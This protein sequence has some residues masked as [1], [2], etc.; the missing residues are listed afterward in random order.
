MGSRPSKV[1]PSMLGIRGQAFRE[2][3][4]VISSGPFLSKSP[5]MP[6][7]QRSSGHAGYL[8]NGFMTPRSRGKSAIYSMARTPYSRVNL[9]T[10]L[11][12]HLLARITSV[13]ISTFF[14]SQVLI[15]I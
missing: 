1:S 2:D 8:E 9:A 15:F 11:K 14:L 13:R 4:T 6:L 12:V 10:N 5:I 3:S 7:V